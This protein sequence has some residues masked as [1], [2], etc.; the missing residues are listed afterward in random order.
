MHTMT[1]EIAQQLSA[2]AA[3]A[4]DQACS[5]QPCVS[6]VP[7]N[8][9]APLLASIATRYACG[10]HTCIKVIFQK[11]ESFVFQEFRVSR[12]TGVGVM[13]KVGQQEPD[14]K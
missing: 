9:P 11:M 5:S 12:G 13:G 6:P 3:F 2:P 10:A 8:P 1:E 7:G 4:E 14:C